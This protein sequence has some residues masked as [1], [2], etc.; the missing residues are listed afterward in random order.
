MI[1]SVS[2]KHPMSDNPP[3]IQVSP[4]NFGYQTPPPNPTRKSSVGV[5]VAIILV[6]VLAMCG[7]LGA[8]GAYRANHS[9][10]TVNGVELTRK[11]YR[12]AKDE[13]YQ[14]MKSFRGGEI[15]SIDLSVKT[16][17]PLSEMIKQYFK[18]LIA[19]EKELDESIE[20]ID[21]EKILGQRLGTDAGRRKSRQE[22][23]TVDKAIYKYVDG[24]A[25][26]LELFASRWGEAFRIDK[27]F[28][29]KAIA[30]FSNLRS[31]YKGVS[32]KRLELL[33]FSDKSKPE[34]DG[35]L[36]LFHTDADID[37]YSKLIDEYNARFENFENTI[38]ANQR[39]GSAALA[40][41]LRSLK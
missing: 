4:G 16:T 8:F 18:D 41:A 22:T 10:I 31:K 27:S 23:A 15:A 29:D 21:V 12:D 33:D 13:I 32:E 30:N 1:E 3:P 38:Q 37:R 19:C 7:G 34:T 35:K 36:L 39:S 28:G 20:G 11:Q 6:I 14:M 25:A 17:N 26:V 40:D 9:G 5:V 24:Q 2:V